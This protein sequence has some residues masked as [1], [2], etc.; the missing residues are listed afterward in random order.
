MAESIK[1]EINEKEIK[2]LT[3]EYLAQKADMLRYYNTLF[4]LLSSSIHS[5]VRD[6][7]QYLED[8]SLEE[9]QSFSWGPDVS[10]LDD[11]LMPA[12]E[13]LFIA[14]RAVTDLF[15][16]SNFDDAFQSKWNTFTELIKTVE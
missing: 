11:I 16:F 8:K 6:M 12:C 13:I 5:R 2:P 14:A 4:V 10:G 15:K 7:G 3:S 9:L 1:Q